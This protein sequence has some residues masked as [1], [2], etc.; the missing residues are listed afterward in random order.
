[1]SRPIDP[2]WLDSLSICRRPVAALALALREMV[3]AE[4][5]D[6]VE[7]MYRNH[8]TAIWF[9]FGPKTNDMLLYIAT[10]TSHVNLGFCRGANLPDPEHVLKGEGKIMRHIKFRSET[11]LERP[12]VRRYIRAAMEQVNESVV[13]GGNR[14]KRTP[15][16]KPKPKTAR[17]S[18]SAHHRPVE[19]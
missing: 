17:E 5:P 3:L 9:G 14:R 13:E 15:R 1:M 8:P 2:E 6:A 16:G 18:R 12:F 19:C 11:D 10:A 4:A 7:K